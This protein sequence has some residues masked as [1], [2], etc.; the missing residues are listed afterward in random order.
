MEATLLVWTLKHDVVSSEC[1]EHSYTHTRINR[2]ILDIR[3][4]FRK[5]TYISL[6]YT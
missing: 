6:V 1:N 2:L 5:I 4:R 3:I